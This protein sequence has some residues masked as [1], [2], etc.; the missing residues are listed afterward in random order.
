MVTLRGGCCSLWSL[1]AEALAVMRASRPDCV[2]LDLM[3]PVLD[4]WEFLRAYRRERLSASTPVLVVSVS[5]SLAEAVRREFGVEHILI[6]PFDIDALL[7]AVKR[8]L[9]GRASAR[10]GLRAQGP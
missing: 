9:D 8:L 4:G 10:H 1:R 3:M 2:V 6:K 5:H 7:E